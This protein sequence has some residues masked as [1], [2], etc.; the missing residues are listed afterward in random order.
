MET[1]LGVR[2]TLFDPRRRP[3]SWNTPH[4]SADFVHR[5]SCSPLASVFYV[6]GALP[7]HGLE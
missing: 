3:R 7:N 1:I 5:D 4:P 6:H 2:N